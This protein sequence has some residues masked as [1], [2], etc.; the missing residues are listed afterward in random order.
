MSTSR[1]RPGS[2]KVTG[3][4]LRSAGGLRSTWITSLATLSLTRPGGPALYGRQLTLTGKAAGVKGAVLS[5][6][7]DGVWT[8]VAGPGAT[9]ALKVKLLAPASFRITAGNL[10]SAVSRVPVSPVVTARADATSTVSGAVKP[11]PP[12]RRS[13]SSSTTGAAGRRRRRPRLGP[14][15]EYW[16]VPPEP[17]PARCALPPHRD[18]PRD[19]RDRSSFGEAVRARGRRSG[20]LRARCRCR[21]LRRRSAEG[22]RPP[23]FALLLPDA[24]QPRPASR[25]RRRAGNR[26]AARRSAWRDLRRTPWLPA[27]C[28]RAERPARGQAVAPRRHAGVRLLGHERT[29][30]RAPPVRVGDHRFGHRCD[31]P[32]SSAD[33]IV[34]GGTK[35]FVGGSASVDTRGARHVRRRADRRR[36]DNAAGIAGMVPSAELLVAKVVVAVT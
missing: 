18:S 8:Q 30:P 11:L 33:K 27:S 29:R 17:G 3:A 15:G 25:G 12:A 21:A 28:V 14:A 10:T 16:I 36:V 19:F 24:E 4:V 32:W 34:K 9:L 20:A 1:P 5:Q 13:S 22:R 35:S 26:A 7:I 2:S 23:R 31:S 6:R